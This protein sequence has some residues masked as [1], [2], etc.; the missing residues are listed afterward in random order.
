MDMVLVLLFG[1]M[2]CCWDYGLLFWRRMSLI[3]LDLN[4]IA[5]LLCRISI[6]FI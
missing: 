2:G 5:G 1:M 6:L 4:L 3:L